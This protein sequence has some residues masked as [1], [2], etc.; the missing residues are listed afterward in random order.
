MAIVVS[1]RKPQPQR[2][3]CDGDGKDEIVYGACTI[4]DNGKGLYTTGLG[5]GD[6]LHFSDLDPDRNGLE[7]WQCHEGGSGATFRDAKT[8]SIIFR[9]QDSGDVG[10]ACAADVIASSKGAEVW[11]SGS[12]AFSTCKG[13]SAGT[14]PSQINFAIWWDG[15][16]L[17]ELLDKTTISKYNGSSLLSA[18][19]CT[20]ING[21]KAN[22]SL[23]AKF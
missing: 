14:K 9:L 5:H 8:G 1:W 18:S 20:S 15:D 23:S 13:A 21:T 16:L 7:V 17:R 4:D 22:P 19:N 12:T 6:A 11:A 3:W 10:R 2:R